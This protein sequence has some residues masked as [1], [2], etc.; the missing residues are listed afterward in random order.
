MSS[1]H[2]R[3]FDSL[4]DM[5][6]GVVVGGDVGHSSGDDIGSNGNDA[7]GVVSGVRGI[8]PVNDGGGDNIS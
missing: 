6:V 3:L 2:N 8:G 7:G 5:S 4:G 1:S